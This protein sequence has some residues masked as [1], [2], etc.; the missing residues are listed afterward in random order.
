MSD[1]P[2]SPTLDPSAERLS[3]REKFSYGF[4]DFASCLYWTVISSYILI[5]YTDIFGITAA[6]AGYMLLVS[7][8]TDAFFDPVIGMLADRTKSR[9]GKFRPYLLWVCVPLALAA[10]FTFFVPDFSDKGKLLWA[11]LTFNAMMILYTTINIPY[12]AMLGVITPN[13]R[14]RTALSSIKFVGAFAA[15]IVVNATLLPMTKIGGWLGASTVQQGWKLAFVIYG[16]VAVASFLIVFFNTRE[17]VLSPRIQQQTSGLRSIFN[18]IGDLL[19][20]GPWLILLATTLT[21][22]LF[23]ALRGNVTV[24]YFKYYVVQQ[25]LTLPSFLPAKIAGT[26]VWGWESLVSLFNT[27]NQI[28]SLIGAML[29]PMFARL[30]GRKSAFIILFVVAI[31]STASF[32]LLRPDQLLLIYGIN[33][34]GSIAGGPL[35]PL[36]MAMYADTADYAEWKKGRRATGLIFSASIFC[37]KQGWG[38]GAGLTALLMSSVGFVANQNQSSGSLHGLVLLMSLLPAGVGIVSLL[39]VLVYP[40][41]EQRMTEIAETLRVR[42]AA[43]ASTA[44]AS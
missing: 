23:V 27:S 20:N 34:L 19:T 18:D 16:V 9:W 8:T 6:S 14:E 4:G 26:Q 10:F 41:N 12:T 5:F 29:V 40:L 38:W 13:P 31:G 21:F 25:T 22:I 43:E 1:T 15:G 35:S 7:R 2:A 39:I 28:L 37:Q 36:L 33:A 17:R 44:P 42:R 32:Y 3:A 30:V 24:H 11:Y